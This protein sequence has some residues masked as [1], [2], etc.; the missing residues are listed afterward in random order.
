[1]SDFDA[2]S[3]VT[4]LTI[5][6]YGKCK[7]KVPPVPKYRSVW[8]REGS[9]RISNDSTVGLWNTY[10]HMKDEVR[11]TVKRRSIHGFT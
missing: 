10:G 5:L 8:R 6:K 7:D 3:T 9:S 2:G 4:Q 11:K 1:V